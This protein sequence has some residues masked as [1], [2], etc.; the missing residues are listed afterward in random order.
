[1]KKPTMKMA[2]IALTLLF[3]S[4]SNIKAQ[5]DFNL[6]AMTASDIE[7]PDEL[8]QKGIFDWIKPDNNSD[9]KIEKEWTI[10][11]FMNAKNDLSDS[12]LLGLVGKWAVKDIKEMKKVGTTDKVNIVVEHGAAG[13]GSKRMLIK[14]KTSIFSSGEKVYGEYPDADMGDYKRVIEFVKWSKKEF[15]AKKYML[16]LW[17]HGLGW[18]DPKMDTMTAGTGTSNKGI[19]FDDETKNYVRTKELGEILKQSGYIDLFVLNAC[20]MQMAEVAYEVKDYTGLMVGSEETMLAYGF[21]YEKLLNFMNSNTR[22]SN[23][24]ISN[25]FTNWYKEFFANGLNM[26]PV[27]IPMDDIGGTLSVINLKAMNQ[28]PAYLNAFSKAIMA[29]N[30]ESAVKHAIQNV[31]RFT[32]IDPS[33]TEKL[34]S[35]YADLYDFV[36]LVSERAEKQETVQAAENLMTFINSSLILGNIGINGD[37]SNGYD[38]T[39]VGGI[40][41]ETTRKLKKSFPLGDF[42][43]TPYN[44]LSLS[45]DSLW[46]EFVSWSNNVWTK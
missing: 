21:N 19:L 8:N 43:E 3:F 25:F 6:N 23:A 5:N 18:L 38:Y 11:V 35:S 12:H 27:D 15:P 13:K 20:L 16:V 32:S 4:V 37:K 22:A 2:A 40:A 42:F 41:V 24:E 9:E 14:K 28:L 1:M 34:L 17:N 33:D 30:E 29:N 10:M 7:F 44:T 45:Q 46:D 31:I 36:R 39:K 26:G